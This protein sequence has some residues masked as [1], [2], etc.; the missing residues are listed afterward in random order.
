MIEKQNQA[1]LLEYI[2]LNHPFGFGIET[3]NIGLMA[4]LEA[5]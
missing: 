4:Y 5:V 1:H 2:I 3:D